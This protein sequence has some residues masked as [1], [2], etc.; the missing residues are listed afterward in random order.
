MVDW[1]K[2][3][4]LPTKAHVANVLTVV[5]HGCMYT[6]RNVLVPKSPWEQARKPCME[7]IRNRLGG[8]KDL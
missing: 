4:N 3:T 2:N 5:E 1:A 7:Q 8:T 6:D